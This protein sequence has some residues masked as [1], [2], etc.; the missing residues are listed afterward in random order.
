MCIVPI[1]NSRYSGVFR[2]VTSQECDVFSVSQVL[3]QWC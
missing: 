2:A 1:L 3:C